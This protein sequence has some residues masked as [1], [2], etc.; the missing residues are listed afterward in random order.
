MVDIFSKV[1]HQNL[2]SQRDEPWVSFRH[3]RAWPYCSRISEY[4]IDSDILASFKVEIFLYQGHNALLDD[5]EGICGIAFVE[6]HLA[7]LVSLGDAVWSQGVFLIVWEI[8][9]KVEGF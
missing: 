5:V 9:V 7:G 3:Q 2:T 6:D 8:F 4:C 1:L